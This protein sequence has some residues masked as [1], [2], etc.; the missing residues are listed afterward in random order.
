MLTSQS[1]IFKGRGIMRCTCTCTYDY[2][3]LTCSS[4]V[5]RGLRVLEFIGLT[6]CLHWPQPIN[7]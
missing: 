7:E 3:L 6:K 1:I 5:S 4:G 2:N